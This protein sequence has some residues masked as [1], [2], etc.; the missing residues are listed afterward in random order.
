MHGNSQN[1]LCPGRGSDDTHMICPHWYTLDLME[2]W[3]CFP[4]SC[5]TSSCN[6]H[7]SLRQNVP[8]VIDSD[9]P[10][11]WQALQMGFLGFWKAQ[12][13]N[14]TNDRNFVIYYYHLILLLLSRERRRVSDSQS[15]FTVLEGGSS[16]QYFQRSILPMLLGMS[17]L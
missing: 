3:N 12:E 5:H 16:G 8:V 9:I 15:R 7:T 1:K 13:L 17:T 11:T 6:S 10:N 14:D 2:N 4:E